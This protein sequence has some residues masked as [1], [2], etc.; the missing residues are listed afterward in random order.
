MYKN[1]ESVKSFN[2]LLNNVIQGN[3]EKLFELLPDNSIDLV[4]TDPPY[5][6]KVK[7]AVGGGIMTQE[8]KKHLYKL[9]DTF[10][11]SF[12]PENFLVSIQRVLKMFNAYIFTNKTLL[13]R[14]IKF[15]EDNNYNW[16][17]LLWGKTNPL[18]LFKG[19]YMFDKEYIIFIY[20]KGAYFNSTLNYK[21]YF[22]IKTFPIRSGVE[23]FNTH[24]T[25]KPDSLLT[26][27][28]K[29]SSKIDNIVLDPFMGSWTT[30]VVAN[31]LH[32]KFIGV[33]VIDEYC[34]IGETRLNQQSLF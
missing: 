16:E 34:A 21:N 11:F 6:F 18:P 4:V 32:R 31:S 7:S 29:I 17:I 3:N 23:K 13:T 8:N 28:I 20:E 19:H 2:Q 9:E 27:M 5:E 14:Y 30:A 33:E 25:V 22:T 15:A 24:P 10:G 26:S 1:I 12:S